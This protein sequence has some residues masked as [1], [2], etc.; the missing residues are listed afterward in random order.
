MKPRSSIQYQIPA[1]PNCVH[2]FPKGSVT[3]VFGTIVAWELGWAGRIYGH[4]R[5]SVGDVH[6]TANRDTLPLHLGV[7]SSVRVRVMRT[8]SDDDPGL[9]VFGTVNAAAWEP[10]QTSWTPTA[11]HHREVSMRK[12]RSLLSLLDPA[13]QG[14]FMSLMVDAQ[15]QRR[16]FW[17]PCASDHH[18]YPGGLFDTSVAAALAAYG[19]TSIPE[20]DRGLAAIASLVFDIGKVFD[21]R[22][23]PDTVRHWPALEAHPQTERRLARPLARLALVYPDCAEDLRRLF[24]SRDEADVAHGPSRIGVLRGRVLRAVE[25]GWALSTSGLTPATLPDGVA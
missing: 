25:T 16:F 7:G 17:R 1:G 20:L 5:L 21:D 13:L 18:C 23:Q 10:S 11:L 2:L 24:A 6:I 9:R 14:L 12:L 8:H 3:T 19:D 4:L 15:V 22:L